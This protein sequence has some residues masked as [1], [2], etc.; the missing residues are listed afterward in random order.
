MIFELTNSFKYNYNLIIEKTQVQ[1]V[2]ES[3]VVDNSIE[4]SNIS[5][6]PK[7]FE[8]TTNQITLIRINFV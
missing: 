7:E 1:N 5:I 2:L 6:T 3:C 8:L 4:I